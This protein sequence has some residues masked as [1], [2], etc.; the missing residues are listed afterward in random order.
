M[1]IIFRYQSLYLLI[2][3]SMLLNSCGKTVP[4]V[5]DESCMPPL[6][7]IAYPV[8]IPPSLD[9]EEKPEIGP[10]GGWQ[11]ESALPG[12]LETDHNPRI[13]TTSDEVWVMSL[14]GTRVFRY[15][16][17]TRE[18]KTYSTIDDF[19]AAPANL[20]LTKDGSL[21]GMDAI[22]DG[23]ASRDNFPLLSWYNKNTDRFEFVKDVDGLLDNVSPISYRADIA[24]D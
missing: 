18:W 10:L 9:D 2:L 22:S 7:K 21:W 24:E 13:V 4:D 5:T 12:P 1:R 23:F 8:G 3:G 16:K 17:N 11:L 19:S 20:L 14:S 6:K 15:D